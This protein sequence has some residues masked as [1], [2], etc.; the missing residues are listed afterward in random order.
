MII[1][2]SLI[3]SIIIEATLFM[4][5][6][7]GKSKIA[8]VLAI[9][10]G[11]SLFLIRGGDRYSGLF[12]SDNVVASVSGT[13]ISTS[14]FLRVMQMNVNQYSQMFGK[15]LTAEEIQAFQIHSM[16]L[17][18]LVNNAV[19]ENEF[20]KQQF[21]IDETV[22]ASETKKRF[23]NLYNSNNKL[24]ETALNAFLSQQNLKID[25]LVKIIDYEARSRAFDKLFFDIGYPKKIQKVL[26]KHNNHIRNINLVQFNIDD[27]QLPNFNDLD[28]SI[29]NTSIIEFFD[30]NL[31]S[32]MVPEKRS[33]SYI[34][35]DPNNFKDQFTPSDSQIESYFNNNKS[36]FLEPE[37]RDFIQFN[38]KDLESAN[39]FKN[40][41]LALN[42]SEVTE[43]ANNNNILF[44][45]FSKVSENEVLENL[46]NA[47]F[48]LEKNQVSEVVETA[49]AKHI[50]VLNNIYPKKQATLN[51]SKQEITDTLLQVEV[52]SFIID[53]KNKISQQIL[54][55]LSL[56][57]IAINNSLSIE[58][59]NNAERNNIQAENDLIK[60]QVIA[61]GFASNKDFVSDIEELDD[62]RSFIVNVDNIDN[63]RPYELKEIFEVVSSDWIDTLKIESINTQINKILESSKSLEEIANFVKKEILNE[64]M[65][66]D[67]NLF[68]TTLKNTVFADEINQISLSI[69]NKDVFISQLK[70]ISFPKK[71]TNNV[72]GVSM[73]SELRSNFGA[74][75]IKNKKISTNDNLIQAL[76][77]QY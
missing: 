45:E 68:P 44:N 73:L 76:I 28:I 38:F 31:N 22:V 2:I 67:S 25:D 10:F 72:Q 74:E 66:L 50:V 55:G 47:I 77:S 37:R 60:N 32:Y 1:I 11:L 69:S 12:G 53:L 57:E 4:F 3:E 19:F 27:F 41:I 43:Y 65:K 9:L 18:Q 35:I 48:N 23:P 17:G 24:N 46:S 62:S 7:L 61:K 6:S 52:E 29:N 64:D 33:M 49:L 63:E 30:Q 70:Q 15:P 42:S 58:N 36:I 40:N 16:A 21:I 75:I 56:N 34:I 13:P 20:D 54:D 26:N 8:L 71:E 5:R 51:E 59:L 39:I 14:K